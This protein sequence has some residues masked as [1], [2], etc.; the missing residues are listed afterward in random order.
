MIDVA[1][2]SVLATAVVVV[3]CFTAHLQVSDVAMHM[4][5]QNIFV[6]SGR[7]GQMKVVQDDPGALQGC[8]VCFLP[9]F[10]AISLQFAEVDLTFEWEVEDDAPPKSKTDAPKTKT[11]KSH[12]TKC[13][14]SAHFSRAVRCSLCACCVLL[15]PPLCMLK[16]H[17][18]VSFHPSVSW[19]PFQPQANGSRVNVRC[20]LEMTPDG[21]ARARN[22]IPG[23]RCARWRRRWRGCRTDMRR[24]RRR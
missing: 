17:A 8:R 14:S 19:S 15:L 18:V 23:T 3:S 6:H 16:L 22:L 11:V 24:A 13:V 12:E 5:N 1:A 10:T 4:T 21:S 2:L 20:S 7:S 9:F